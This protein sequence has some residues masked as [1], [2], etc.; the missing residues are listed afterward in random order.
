MH[1]T[2]KPVTDTIYQPDEILV[3]VQKFLD[4]NPN[5]IISILGAT[6][7]GKTGFSVWLAHWI[8]K[9]IGKKSEIIS[10][11]SRQIFRKINIASAK[12]TTEEMRNIPHHGLDLIDPDQ[13]FSAYEFKQYAFAKIHDIQAK[14]KISILCGGTMLWLD[15]IT[16]N[17]E[18]STDPNQKSNTK[19]PPLFPTLKIGLYW[20]RNKLYARINL[21]SKLMFENGLIEETKTLMQK[22]RLKEIPFVPRTNK[23]PA[24]KKNNS[25]FYLRA[26]KLFKKT[27]GIKPKF[28]ASA[29][30][31]FG[32]QELIPYIKGQRTY[33]EVLANNQQ[34]NRKYAKRQLTWWRGR[35][36]VIWIDAEAFKKTKVASSS[37]LA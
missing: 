22:Y 14:L 17:Y 33:E 30:T 19:N 31:S 36:D 34:R 4:K 8:E 6:T 11:D 27:I 26:K 1:K 23:K 15:A 7:S 10:V 9:K 12:I 24:Q 16:E 20:E 2:Q 13:E 29:L 21:R 3:R 32:Y 25:S 28:S 35:E 18:F 37:N 5:G